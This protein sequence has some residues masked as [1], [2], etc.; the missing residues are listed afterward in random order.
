M[1]R[2]SSAQ[3][4]LVERGQRRNHAE[5]RFER[6]VTYLMPKQLWDS[7]VKGSKYWSIRGSYSQ[8]HRSGIN[9]CGSGH[10]FGSVLGVNGHSNWCLISEVSFVKRMEVCRRNHTFRG[11]VHCLYCKATSGE[12][13][14]RFLVRP[15]SLFVSGDD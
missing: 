11:M 14:A 4:R 15:F 9:L 10:T 13:L 1:A 12:H 6:I 3:A 5:S 2:Y 8:D 7:S